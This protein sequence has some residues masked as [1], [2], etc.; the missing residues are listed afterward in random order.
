MIGRITGQLAAA[1]GGEIVVDVGGV[2]YELQVSLNTLFAL[3]PVGE[4][5]SLVTHFVVREDAQLLFG[6]LDQQERT[7]FRLLIKV[8]GVGPKMGLAIL[9]GMSVTELQR[10]VASDDILRLTKLPGVG[11]KTAER[12]LIELRDKVDL[13][14]FDSAAGALVDTA[15]LA[16]DEAVAALAALGYRSSDAEK[17]IAKVNSG[18]LSTEALVKAALRNL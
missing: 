14:T 10:A 8:N 12:L 1:E 6:F 18:E 7:L 16:A 3:P 13:S 15:S 17:M 11:K 2:G 5:V 9:S 4:R